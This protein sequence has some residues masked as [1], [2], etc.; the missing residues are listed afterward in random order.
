MK[1]KPEEIF[2]ALSVKTRLKII[3]LLKSNGPLGTKKIAEDLGIT[4]AG[5]SQHLKVLKQVGLVSSKRNGYYIPYDINLKNLEHCRCT[6]NEVCT[7]GCHENGCDGSK[8]SLEDLYKYE[9]E[10]AN[11]LKRVR[12]RIKELE[13]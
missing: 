13:K 7:C 2:K 4:T 5:V 3:H 8:R 11:E 12:N 9:N 1:P 6:I 10:L